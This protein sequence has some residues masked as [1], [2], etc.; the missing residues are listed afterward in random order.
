[1]WET[2][3]VTDDNGVWHELTPAPFA[4]DI[5]ALGVAYWEDVTHTDGSMLTYTQFVAKIG[6]K[7]AKGADERVRKMYHNIKAHV[8]GIQNTTAW[9]A[10][11]QQRER[12]RIGLEEGYVPRARGE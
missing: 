5:A 6:L 11:K 9:S 4:R 8:H 10:W 1:M 12:Q 7:D 3:H 2:D